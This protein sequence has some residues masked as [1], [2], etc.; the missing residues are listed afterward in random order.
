[1][2]MAP[3]CA[4]LISSIAANG[5]MRPAS[6]S[7]APAAIDA[8]KRVEL[9]RRHADGGRRFAGFDG[10]EAGGEDRCDLVHAVFPLYRARHRWALN[11][12]CD[13]GASGPGRP[14]AFV[15]GCAVPRSASLPRPSLRREPG[16][17]VAVGRGERDWWT[18]GRRPPPV[19]AEAQAPEDGRSRA[20][21]PAKPR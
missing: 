21:V 3:R 11:D 15:C 6:R 9:G 19:E 2:L 17:S 10:L 7:E 14:S 18:P 16:R 1:M 4:C 20:V 12:G 13:D 5:W 8:E